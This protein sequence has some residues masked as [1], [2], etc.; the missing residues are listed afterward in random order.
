MRT[1]E[2]VLTIQH[3]YYARQAFERIA[4]EANARFGLLRRDSRAREV[5]LPFPFYVKPAKAAFSVLARRVDS[6]AEL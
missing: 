2:A 1:C 4:P 3:K 5:P 6:F